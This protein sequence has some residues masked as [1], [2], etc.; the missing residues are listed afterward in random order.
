MGAR[1]ASSS[2]AILRVHLEQAAVLVAEHELDQSMLQRLEPARRPEHMAE[3]AIFVGRQGGQ[4]RPLRDQLRL[5]VLDAREDLEGRLQVV[6]AHVRDGRAQLVEDELEPQLAGLV[7]D[8]EEH[9]VVV[10]RVAQGHL[11]GEELVELQIAPVRH[12]VLEVGDH[13]FVEWHGAL[14]P[15]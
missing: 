11:R 14:L 8:D 4:H 6:A 12:A 15:P 9:L 13:A 3:L 2:W 5:D 1:S 7:L 10:R